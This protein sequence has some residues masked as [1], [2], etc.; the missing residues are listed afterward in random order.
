MIE[1]RKNRTAKTTMVS[2]RQV[3]LDDMGSTLRGRSESHAAE[4]GVAA[5]VHEDEHDQREG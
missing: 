5:R 3:L 2:S 4:T 1:F